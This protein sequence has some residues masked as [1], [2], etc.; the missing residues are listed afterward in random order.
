MCRQFI[1]ISY[2]LLLALLFHACGE[3]R[4]AENG[5]WGSDRT[6]IRVYA[7]VVP[8]TDKV[9][10]CNSVDNY[11]V[12]LINTSVINEDL[13]ENVLYLEKYSFE[14]E[15]VDSDSPPIAPGAVNNKR[16]LPVNGMDLIMVDSE[17]KKKFLE[18]LNSGTYSSNDS[19]AYSIIY[20][21]GGVDEYGSGFGVIASTEFSIGKYSACTP[22]VLP[23]EISLVGILNPES[24]EDASD[25]VK[26]YITG[27]IGPYTVY[28]DNTSKIPAPGKLGAGVSEFT[29]DPDSVS[30]SLVVKLTVVDSTGASA[31]ASVTINP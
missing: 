28:S 16:Q 6:N 3:E 22:S 10:I 1:I 15:P 25:D 2:V 11:V 18:D 24:P 8:E 20:T 29:V 14:F 5:T 27:G 7:E 13:P 12:A 17:R 21:F 4:K 23:A 19:Q 30:S 26:F 9:D 31:F